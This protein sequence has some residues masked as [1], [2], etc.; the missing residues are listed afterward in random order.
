MSGG[1]FQS[2]GWEED[3]LPNGFLLYHLSSNSEK[4][5]N[6]FTVAILGQR[7]MFIIVL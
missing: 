6:Y 2:L 3:R 5:V 4:S 7:T 1:Y